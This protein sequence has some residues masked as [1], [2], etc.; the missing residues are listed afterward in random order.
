MGHEHNHTHEMGIPT[1]S[2]GGLNKV[3]LWGIIL[4]VAFVAIEASVGWGVNSMALLSDAGHNLS[5]VCSLLLAMIAFKLSAAAANSKY[6][7]GYKKSSILASLVNA[8]ILAVAIILIVV[9]S[10]KKIETPQPLDGGIIAWIAAVGIV[11][12]G[13]T[14]FAFFKY[15]SHDINVKGAFLH[16]A[17]DT[18]VSVGVLASGIVIKYTGIAIIDPIIGIVI[19]IVILISTWD[20]L[21]QSI[22][23]TLDGVPE[24]INV[25]DIED[26]LRAIDGVQDIHHVHVWALSTTQNAITAHILVQAKDMA[27]MAELKAKIRDILSEG[28]ICHATL[29]FETP[30]EHCCHQCCE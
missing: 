9:E 22:R 11:V 28:G 27:R 18:L 14:T 16:M 15:R 19:A 25:Q 26:K 29:E 23:L 20:L 13:L 10:V 6:T 5:D 3:F 8:I 17:A 1:G 4:N 2:K 21:K 7:Y 30:E 24:D 12:N